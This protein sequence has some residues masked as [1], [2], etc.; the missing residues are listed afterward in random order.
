M[1]REGRRR[2]LGWTLPALVLVVAAGLGL[3]LLL[4]PSGHGRASD[5]SRGTG[6]ATAEVRHQTLVAQTQLNGTLGYGAT[7]DI[8]IPA[9]TDAAALK[10]AQDAVTNAAATR[11]GDSTDLSDT[12]A[13]GSQGID[14]AR[15]TVAQ[16]ER[17]LAAAE[18]TRATS[19]SSGASA[20]CTQASQQVASARAQLTQAKA[21]LGS[22]RA[23]ARAANNQAAT[24]LAA[25][26]DALASARAALADA[27]RRATNPGL[28]YTA[29]AAVGTVIRRGERLYAVDGVTVP[30]F[31]GDVTLWRALRRG[32]TPGADVKALNGNLAALGY[33]A[34]LAGRSD[35]SAATERAV[36]Q[37]QKDR[38]AQV[39]GI[40]AL[41]DVVFR[42][43]AVVVTADTAV[44]GQAAT[45]GGV[46]LTSSPT[47]KVVT[48]KLSATQQGQVTA[49]DEVSITL[50]DGT[51]TEGKVVA[52]GTIASATSGDDGS[53]SGA[54]GGSGGGSDK[55]ATLPVTVSLD[56]P[57]SAT[58]LD[59]APVLVGI[60]TSS[61]A[62]ALVVPVNALLAL[63]GGG[64]AVE[65]VDPDGGHR[66]V[67]V[68]LGLFDDA[69]GLV[70]VTDTDLR[71]GQHVVVPTS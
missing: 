14:A 9:G 1:P 6:T 36:A 4:H 69:K 42:P 50:P 11:K 40:V 17:A 56:D 27:Q 34:T 7:S 57:A 49:G 39:T 29:V 31:Y 59:Q 3:F 23:Q 21:A 5:P 33:D 32:V 43:G 55:G 30:L 61:A 58:G 41:G 19:C 37:W 54:G 64:Y 51:T 18:K 53:G 62:D 47:D 8:V 26:D 35:F 46:V 67:A 20:D 60:T 52:V 44:A 66:L 12:E 2:L 45:P 25:D 65:V 24:K 28:T 13:A 10:Q 15:T 22:A 38:H 63:A 70:Q 16:D 71:S 68:G 48:A